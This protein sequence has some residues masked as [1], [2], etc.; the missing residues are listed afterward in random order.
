[1]LLKER[2]SERQADRRRR[3]RKVKVR[4]MERGGDDSYR[5]HFKPSVFS[6]PSSSAIYEYSYV[7]GRH[8]LPSTN[9]SQ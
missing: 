5:L 2:E 6:V 3:I 1:M 7:L 8:S 9:S 4:V